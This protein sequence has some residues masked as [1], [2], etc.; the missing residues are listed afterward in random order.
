M[1]PAIRVWIKL[2]QIQYIS[3][4]LYLLC[5]VL[6]LI[7]SISTF[8]GMIVPMPVKQLWRSDFEYEI[9]ISDWTFI[10]LWNH[11]DTAYFVLKGML[12]HVLGE[13]WDTRWCHQMETFSALL[14]ICAENSPVLGEFPTQRPV[15]WSF[16]V[17][18]DLRL[19]KRLSKQAWGCWFETLSC[20]LWHHCNIIDYSVTA[21]YCAIVLHRIPDRIRCYHNDITSM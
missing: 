12:W 17:F 11:K 6:L 4:V 10:T 3:T 5:C 7:L 16:D 15:T 19:N 1:F 8:L 9:T 21:E 2:S 14:A 18:F 20:P 13:F